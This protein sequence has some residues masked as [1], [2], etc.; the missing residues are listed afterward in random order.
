MLKQAFRPRSTWKNLCIYVSLI[1]LEV[2]IEGYPQVLVK[3]LYL[4]DIIFNYET[5]SLK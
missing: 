2:R 3:I 1:L 5:W 4:S